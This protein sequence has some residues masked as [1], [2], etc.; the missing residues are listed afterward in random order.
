VVII[1][2]TL[3]QGY[4]VQ[5]DIPNEVLTSLNTAWMI[6]G[7]VKLSEF[8]ESHK[9]VI[10]E[11]YPELYHAVESHDQQKILIDRLI[12]AMEPLD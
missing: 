11:Q 5:I 6:S 9:H 10:L 4:D 1:S 7:D 8:W 3:N 12:T 2:V